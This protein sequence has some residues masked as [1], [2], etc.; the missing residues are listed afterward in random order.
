[1]QLAGIDLVTIAPAPIT[2]LSPIDTPF[3]IIQ[4][5]PIKTLFPIY[6][7][8]YSLLDIFSR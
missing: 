7:I 3:N 1:M 6:R 8:C 2:E 5:V 4:R